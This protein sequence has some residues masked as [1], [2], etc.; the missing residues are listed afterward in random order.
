MLYHNIL[1]A[2]ENLDE[3][4]AV[5][6]RGSDW[7]GHGQGT[8]YVLHSIE[9]MG[10]MA[11]N[12]PSFIEFDKERRVEAQKDLDRIASKYHVRFEN[13]VLVEGDPSDAIVGKAKELGAD[14]IVMGNHG[15]VFGGTTAAVL[16][17]APCDILAVRE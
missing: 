7:A 2:A 17:T 14:L 5:L 15:H 6:E 13:E 4:Q 8:L 1:I 9:D 12:I 11:Y 16:K 3:D 10:Y